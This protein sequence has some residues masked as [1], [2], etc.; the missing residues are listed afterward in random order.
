MFEREKGGGV[1]S[2]MRLKLLEVKELG[3][4]I[5]VKQEGNLV[6]WQLETAPPASPS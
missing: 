2:E 1:K 6:T 4:S 5:R 3:A